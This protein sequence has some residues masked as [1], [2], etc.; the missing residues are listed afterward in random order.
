MKPEHFVSIVLVLVAV[1]VVASFLIA[2]VVE[3][4][5][6]HLKLITILG[7]VSETVERTNGLESVVGEIAKDLAIGNGA[8][9]DCV[10]RLEQRLGADGDEVDEVD[11]DDPANRPRVRTYTN[12]NT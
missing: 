6:T 7:A 2:I 11:Y 10:G 4:R 8:L 12:Y 3:L 1:L 9:S 5:R